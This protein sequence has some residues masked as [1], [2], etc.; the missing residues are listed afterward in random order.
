MAW[1]QG[2]TTPVW[3]YNSTWP[4]VFAMDASEGVLIDCLLDHEF[5]E[6][7]E[8][9]KM[10]AVALVKQAYKSHQFLVTVNSY[11]LLS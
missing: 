8:F 4:C 10:N 3:F 11:M 7:L 6:F 2:Y 9:L 5:L 1:E